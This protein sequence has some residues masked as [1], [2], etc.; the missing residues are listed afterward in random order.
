[1]DALERRSGNDERVGVAQTPAIGLFADIPGWIWAGCLSAWAAIF[2]LFIAFFATSAGAAFAVTIAA[3][4][5]LM[6]FGLPAALAAQSP[7]G[8]HECN[9]VIQTRTGP[10]TVNAAA[11]QIL[12]IPVSAV[13][14]LIAFIVLAK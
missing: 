5:A 4:F 14:G 2:G 1:M 3:L 10:L 9:G 12:V 7:C 8:D 13:I 6:A 11:T